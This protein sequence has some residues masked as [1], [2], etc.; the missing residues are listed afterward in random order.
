[1]T[2]GP[3]FI[4]DDAV[5]NLQSHMGDTAAWALERA[6]GAWPRA[7]EALRRRFVYSISDFPYK[8]Y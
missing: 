5:E 6:V 4:S 8:L 7:V 3:C 2:D 1:M